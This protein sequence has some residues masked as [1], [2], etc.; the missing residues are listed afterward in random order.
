LLTPAEWSI[1]AL[2]PT[3]KWMTFCKPDMSS[4]NSS[5]GKYSELS[6]DQLIALLR[7]RDE[8]RLGLVW[9]RDPEVVE[10]D[11]SINDDFVA[12]DYVESLS[13]GETAYQNLLIE[14]DNYDALRALRMTHAGRIKCIEIDPPYNTGNNDFIYNDVFLNKDHSYRHSVWLE[15]MHKRLLIARDLLTDDGVIFVHIGEEEVHRLGC[16]MDQVFPGQKVGTFVWRTRSGANDSKEYFRST[17]HEYVLCYANA[18]FTFAGSVKENDAYSNPDGDERGPWVNGDLTKAH[19]IKQ[20]GDAFYPIR[21]PETDVWYACDPDQVWRFAS[22]TKLKP[23]Q[24]IRTKTMEQ[25]I[26]EKKVL[27][28]TDTRTIRYESLKELES[29]IDIGTAPRNIRRDIPDLKF[30]IGK[31][32]GYGKPR[33]KRHLSELKRSEKPFSTW[34]RPTSDKEAAPEDIL[35]LEVGGTTEGTSLIQQMLGNKDF[36]YPKPLSL[37]YGLLKQSTGPDD[38]VLD[39][40]GGSGTTGHAVLALNAEDD[41]NR[42]FIVVSSTEATAKEP[43]KNVCRDICRQRLAKAIEGYDYRTKDKLKHVE[44]LGGNFAYLRTRR[45]PPGKVVRK[46]AHTQVWTAL[47]LMHLE[48]VNPRPLSSPIWKA[49][50]DN[51]LL[52]YL[53]KMDAAALKVLKKEPLS[54]AVIYS[55]QPEMVAQHV[56]KSVSVRPIPQFLM[57]RFGIKP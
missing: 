57:E 34:I 52:V 54:G 55:W 38:I 15:F 44:G 33:Y 9:E 42:R 23:G 2:A 1:L 24:K 39:F 20:R 16:L 4:N 48:S 5:A 14:G 50:D 37:L 47:Q 10:G 46:L 29:A 49:G 8:T 22:E 43:E 26:R 27:W 56:G 30:W 25:I 11:Q 13:S 7:Q 45:L 41:G 19:T 51:I 18:S 6:K 36:P 17:D 35:S 12:L 40:F 53:P 21:N 32:I 28:P 3:I 31:T